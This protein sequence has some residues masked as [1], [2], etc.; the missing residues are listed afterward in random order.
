MKDICC[1]YCMN[2]L[3][4]SALVRECNQCGTKMVPDMRTKMELLRGRVPSCKHSGC[5]GQL[6]RVICPHCNKLLPPQIA[7]Y[8][9]YLRF[10]LVGPTNCGKTN[11]I[12]TMVNEMGSIGAHR[13]YLE[14]MN[15][16]TSLYQQ[17]NH[18]MLYN[19]KTKLP[20]TQSVQ[21]LQWNLFD[22]QGM[23]ERHQNCY[24]LTIFDGAGEEQ[25]KVLNLE[26]T[27]SAYISGSKMIMLL[28]DP[29]LISGV[30]NAMG[31]PVYNPWAHRQKCPGLSQINSFKILFSTS[32]NHVVSAKQARLKFPS[33]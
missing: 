32:K 33:P 11:Y 1:P 9:R 24:S 13:F 10:A 23:T 22:K 7:R 17:Q 20:A 3:S 30:V 5:N 16:S 18:N 28:L 14:P 26:P 8:D 19:D 21:P 27:I 6:S 31:G 15:S 4:E 2:L 29:L 12:T 25:A